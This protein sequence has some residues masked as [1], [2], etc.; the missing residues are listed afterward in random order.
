LGG[1][2]TV[3]MIRRYAHLNVESLRSYADAIPTILLQS[4]EAV[5]LSVG[6]KSVSP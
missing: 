1:W 4:A 6:R 3:T 2:K 5:K